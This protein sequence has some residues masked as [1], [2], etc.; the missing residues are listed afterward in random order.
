MASADAWLRQPCRL[1]RGIPMVGAFAHNW[2]RV[3]AFQSRAEDI[4]LATFPKSGTTWI[5]EIV[6]MLLHGGDPE[7]C[8]RDAIERRV[9]LLEFAVPGRLPAGTDLLA[10]RPSPRVVKTHLPAHMLPPPFWLHGCKVVYVARNAKDVAVSFYHFH[11]MN[12]L[13]PHAGAWAEYLEEFVAGRVPYGSWYDHVKGYWERRKEHPILYLFYEDMKEDPRREI[14]KVAQFL[15]RELPPAVLDAIARHTSFETMRDNPAT[16]YTMVPAD[17]MDHQASPFMR[18]GERHPAHAVFP[19]L[20]PV[21][22]PLT[23]SRPAPGVAGDWKNHFTV[24][25]SERFDEDYARK[26]AGTDLRFRTEL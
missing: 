1:V 8:K 26:M 9:P 22:V 20:L 2:E 3:D 12:Q 18:K 23:P 5:C 15:Q 7:Q 21:V 6:D 16:N 10:G 4:V 25:Q 17:L 11:L 14:R 24:A 13:L 19:S